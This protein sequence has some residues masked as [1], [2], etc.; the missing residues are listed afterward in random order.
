MG[1]DSVAQARLGDSEGAHQK[2]GAG[3]PPQALGL[4]VRELNSS[5]HMQNCYHKF[6]PTTG[7]VLGTCSDLIFLNISALLSQINQ[8]RAFL[9]GPQEAGRHSLRVAGPA[10]SV[11]PARSGGAQVTV[12]GSSAPGPLG[13]EQDPGG[14][15]KVQWGNC[16]GSWQAVFA[17]VLV[18]RSRSLSAASSG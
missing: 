5:D 3:G 14:V 4:V 9:E 15:S 6:H 1:W 8:A 16:S 12:K 18:L 2:P 7:R 17:P 10:G 13:P 11:G